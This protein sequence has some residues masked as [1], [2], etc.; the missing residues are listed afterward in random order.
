MA[1]TRKK[2]LYPSDAELVRETL[3]SQGWQLIRER[4]ERAAAIKA[5]ELLQPLDQVKTATL[6]GEVAGL[7]LALEIP[8]IV[9]QEAK[10]ASDGEID[11][12]GA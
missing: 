9:M 10:G 5:S 11:G 6:R 3:A 8:A 1:A 2:R 12:G 4:I 7:K